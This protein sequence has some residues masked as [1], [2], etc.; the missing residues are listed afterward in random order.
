MIRL[1]TI[2]RTEKVCGNC[3]HW[4]G[5]REV[6]PDACRFV[7]DSEG[8]CR[9]LAAGG[10]KFVDALTLSTLRPTCGQWQAVVA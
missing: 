2:S 6:G 10:R 1:I 4:E 9:H 8:V 3:V 7:E 5:A